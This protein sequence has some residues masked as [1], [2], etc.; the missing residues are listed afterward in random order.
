M[1]VVKVEKV[2]GPNLRLVWGDNLS[3]P[4]LEVANKEHRSA[5]LHGMEHVVNASLTGTQVA[6]FE[7]LL[8]FDQDALPTRTRNYLLSKV[9]QFLPFRFCGCF[10]TAMGN[11][12]FTV[13]GETLHVFNKENKPVLRLAFFKFSRVIKGSLT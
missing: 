11:F 9:R 2:I 13:K 1:D 6:V 5:I 8:T 7:R 10:D 3:A 12:T 4:V